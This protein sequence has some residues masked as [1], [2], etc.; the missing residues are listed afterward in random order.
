MVSPLKESFKNGSF[1]AVEHSADVVP[2]DI[3]GEE[4]KHSLCWWMESTLNWQELYKL[5]NSLVAIEQRG[6]L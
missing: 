3:T 4:F 1:I 5:D 2:I 6:A